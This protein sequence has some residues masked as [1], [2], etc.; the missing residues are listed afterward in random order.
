LPADLLLSSGG[1][2]YCA[3]ARKAFGSNACD[4]E[5]VAAKKDECEQF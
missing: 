3:T 1:A 4:I 2:P 5:D